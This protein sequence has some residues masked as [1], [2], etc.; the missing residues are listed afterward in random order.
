MPRLLLREHGP[1]AIGVTVGDRG[2]E[3][4]T[5]D[6]RGRKRDMGV[7]GGGE[8]EVDVLQRELAS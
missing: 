8:R 1:V 3:A 7:P 6:V 4:V 2:Q 5:E